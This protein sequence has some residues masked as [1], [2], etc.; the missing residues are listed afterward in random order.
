MLMV[1]VV[2]AILSVGIAQ[3]GVFFAKAQQVAL[4]ARVGAAKASQ[5]ALPETPDPID[6]VPED[7]RDAIQHQLGSSGMQWCHIRLE[8]NATASGDTVVLEADFGEACECPPKTELTSSPAPNTSYVRLTVCVPL[9][10]VFPKQLSY[11]GDSLFAATKTYEHTV[12][13]RYEMSGP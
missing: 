5:I 9:N 13:F 7:V 11:F 1:V 8:H 6:G 10:Q 12:V 3:F 4:A 2:L